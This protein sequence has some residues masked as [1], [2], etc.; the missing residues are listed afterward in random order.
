MEK[1]HPHFAST[2]KEKEKKKASFTR[3]R[4]PKCFGGAERKSSCLFVKWNASQRIFG[5]RRKRDDL[6]GRKLASHFANVAVQWAKAAECHVIGTC[7]TEE[8]EKLLKDLGCDKVINYKKEDIAEVLAKEYPK[9]VNVVWET[10]GG[11]VFDD[12]L[13]HL[14]IRGR[15]VVVGGI[16]GYKTEEKEGF[17]KRDLSSLPIQLMLKSAAVVGFYVL[18]YNEC[19]ASY[20]KFMSESIESGKLKILTDNGE[21]STGSE[22]FGM[23]GIIRGVEHLHSG[24]SSGKVIARKLGSVSF[25]DLKTLDGIVCNNFHQ[26]CKLQGLLEGDQHWYDTLNEAIRTRAPFQLRLLFATICG[27]GEVNDIPEL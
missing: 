27:F 10:I 9:G 24:K 12:C 16:T 20:F 6:E 8:K 3:H 14:S 7:S 15:L 17:V 2:S 23:E 21:K 25:D 13:K 19:F 22:F 18:D 5:V 26:A 11:Q 4:K 1:F